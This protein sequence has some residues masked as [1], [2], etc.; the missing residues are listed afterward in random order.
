MSVPVP[1]L[2]AIPLPGETVG[3][4]KTEESSHTAFSPLTSARNQSTS[5]VSNYPSSCSNPP[6]S[7][8]KSLS[9]PASQTIVDELFKDFLASKQK[10]E[11]STLDQHDPDIVSS[12]EEMSK[13]LDEEI[14]MINGNTISQ[15]QRK[16][17]G[18]WD[19]EEKKSSVNVIGE[20][21]N[22]ESKKGR[23]DCESRKEGGVDV[24]S[25]GADVET[26]DDDD[27][28]NGCK[29]KAGGIK[30][31]IS[32]QSRDWINSGGHDG[33]EEESGV[34]GSSLALLYHGEVLSSSSDESDE[35]SEDSEVVEDGLVETGSLSHSDKEGKSKS[36]KK[37]KHKHKHKKKKKHKSGKGERKNSKEKSFKDDRKEGKKDSKKEKSEEGKKKEEKKERKKEDKKDHKSKNSEKRRHSR[38]RSKSPKRRRTRSRTRSKERHR[39]RTDEWETRSYGGLG[40]PRSDRHHR[41][42]KSRSRSRDRSRSHEK[43]RRRD[44]DERH[45]D[46]E[47]RHRDRER[48]G[49]ERER[50]KDADREKDLRVKIDKSKLRKIAIANVLAAVKAGEQ[51]AD[52]DLATLKAGGKSVEELTDF[53]KKISEKGYSD[54]DSDSEYGR[55]SDGEEGEGP[56]INHPFKLRDPST[57]PNIIMNIRNSKQ[58]PVLTPQAKA[59]QCAQLRLQFPVSSGSQH[60][61][62]EDQWVPVEKTTAPVTATIATPV[63]TT[64]ATPAAVTTVA[65]PAPM[66]QTAAVSAPLNVVAQQDKVFPDPPAE[67]IDIGAI[68]SE[69]LSLVRKLTE[70]PYDVQALCSMHKAQEKSSQ[71]AQSKF[72]PGQF[73]GSTGVQ[74]LTQQE[75]AGPDKKNQAWFKKD[76]LKKA[77]PVQGGIGKWLL[78]KMG[79][80]PGEGLGKNNEG[81]KEPLML[82]FKVDRKG[83]ISEGE[84]TRKG[85]A[86]ARVKKDLSGKH[87]VSALTELCNKRRWG[88][89]NFVIVQE[90][91][92]DHKKSFL[93]KVIVNGAEYQ[94][95]AVSAN[96]KLAKA[97]AASVCLQEL[98]LIPRD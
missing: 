15:N 67:P 22:S 92:P 97:Q 93:F 58:L 30:L 65:I 31:E 40:H 2:D 49:G 94:S 70:N 29:V 51:G 42:S 11:Q 71:W 12:M 37:K 54:S 14:S 35:E 68:V 9:L 75:L 89:P 77:A 43:S 84:N 62:K 17:K 48:G 39:D 45:H 64:V 46:R 16:K 20:K 82:D 88:P 53:C 5:T 41:R 55:H 1:S 72:L 26:A 76:Q 7:G 23:W 63:V 83:L 28:L 18:R 79:W 69:R 52:V 60:R 59:T 85:G 74:P 33:P 13:L 56:F 21:S 4:Q 86:V 98:G 91:G 36:K 6:S 8:T 80:R 81:S 90:S 95:S 19:C 24:I 50:I 73:T 96:K 57:L 3:E 27:E 32:K 78:E 34:G 61:A 44:R 10:E 38:S 87:P 66:S 47:Y 25:Q